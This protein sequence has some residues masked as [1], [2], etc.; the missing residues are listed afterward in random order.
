MNR[1]QLNR[2]STIAMLLAKNFFYM[3][4]ERHQAKEKEERT[5]AQI[6]TFKRKINDFKSIPKK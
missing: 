6:N 1:I 2:P 5:P 4:K 3:D